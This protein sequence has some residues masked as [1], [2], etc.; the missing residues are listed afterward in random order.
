MG[1]M[2]HLFAFYTCSSYTY[3]IWHMC[4]LATTADLPSPGLL[5]YLLI[6]LTTH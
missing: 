3:T 1:V 6:V 2:P 5:L 4:E